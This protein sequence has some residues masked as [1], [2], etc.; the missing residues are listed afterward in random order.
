MNMFYGNTIKHKEFHLK[1]SRYKHKTSHIKTTPRP[2]IITL[3]LINYMQSIALN[4]VHNLLSLDFSC[5]SVFISNTLLVPKST[6]SLLLYD[7]A[8]I[9]PLFAIKCHN[10]LLTS[11]F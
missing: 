2:T 10:N 6:V 9:I 3:Q 7:S 1:T 8:F 11:H 4:A 5:F